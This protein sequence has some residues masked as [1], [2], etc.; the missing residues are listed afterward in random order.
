MLFISYFIFHVSY[1]AIKTFFV[2]HYIDLLFLID[3]SEQM[4][5]DTYII[6][7]LKDKIYY[8]QNFLNYWFDNQNICNYLLN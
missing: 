5:I 3:I 4:Y 2:F 6:L 1:L 7:F 8:S